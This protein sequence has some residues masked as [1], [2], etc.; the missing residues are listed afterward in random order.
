MRYTPQE[1][2]LSLKTAYLVP[3]LRAISKTLK[4]PIKK[5]GVTSLPHSFKILA[6]PDKTSSPVPPTISAL[7]LGMESPP[8]ISGHTATAKP[9]LTKA[10]KISFSKALPSYLQGHPT[11]QALTKSFTF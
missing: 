9:F 1:G 4:A 6:W 7:G 3:S 11:R 5:W 8:N 10:F 2:L